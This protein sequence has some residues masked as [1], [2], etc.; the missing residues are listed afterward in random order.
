MGALQARSSECSGGS[1]ARAETGRSCRLFVCRHEND[2]AAGPAAVCGTSL[3]N[4]NG[5]WYFPGLSRNGPATKPSLNGHDFRQELARLPILARERSAAVVVY[6]RANATGAPG[7]R[8]RPAAKGQRWSRRSHSGLHPTGGRRPGGPVRGRRTG[9]G[10]GLGAAC[11]GFGGRPPLPLAAKAPR[12]GPQPRRPPRAPARSTATGP[13]RLE[14][15]RLEGW[16]ADRYRVVLTS[17]GPGQAPF[18]SDDLGRSAFSYYFEEA[19]RGRADGALGSADGS[20]TVKELAA[21]VT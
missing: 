5:R 21:F 9:A 11:G 14:R 16:S 4:L 2:Q 1:C 15:R 20:V 17:C 12:A 8:P 10:G 6:V 18:A 19:L 7:P 13:A 3:A